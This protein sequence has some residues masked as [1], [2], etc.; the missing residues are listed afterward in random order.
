M[1]RNIIIILALAATTALTAQGQ[2][3][4]APS[5][6]V[7]QADVGFNVEALTK[8]A[9]PVERVNGTV[10]TERD[11]LREMYAIFPYARQHNGFPKAM[12]ADI[13]QGA[14]MMITFEEL[15]YQ[16]ALRRK[17]TIAPERLARAERDFRR[18]FGSP[19]QYQQYLVNEANGSRD[20]MRAQIRRSLLIEDLLKAE[21]ANKSTVTLADAKTFYLKNPDRFKLPELYTL[22]TITVMPPQSANPKQAPSSPTAEQLK[23][24]KIRADEALKQAQQTKTYE[25]FGLLAEK[26]SE[27]DY[28]VMMGTHHP[29]PAEQ[30]PPAILQVVSKLQ[31]GQISGLI[32]VDGAYTI[33]R[34]K[35]HT[36]ARKQTFAE[37]NKGLR[38][39]LQ[40][41]KTEKL[42]REL[43]ARLR[44]TAKIEQL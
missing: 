15:V 36:P 42:R 41:Q 1:K 23:Q 38:T 20:V 11:L 12:E 7:A 19:Q 37:V 43:N 32:Q 26:I 13:R 29:M 21:V 44:K 25:E 3:P 35:E 31:P 10:L 22:Q 28:R 14:L 16:E 27:D 17:M 5:A 24:M 6:N 4:V 8:L 39:Q 34:L 40:K 33:V 2:K 9:K 18:H 30:V